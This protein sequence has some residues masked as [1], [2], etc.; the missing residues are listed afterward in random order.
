[1]KG[2]VA[3]NQ[4]SQSLCYGHVVTTS[5]VIYANLSVIFY[6]FWDLHATPKM[7]NINKQSGVV[8]KPGLVPHQKFTPATTD[9]V[10][11]HPN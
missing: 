7:V 1:M 5:V 6:I 2:F 9:S 4:L 10:V 11:Q 3:V 8:D